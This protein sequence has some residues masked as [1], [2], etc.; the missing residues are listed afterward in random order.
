[1]NR[2]K[3]KETIHAKSLVNDNKKLVKFTDFNDLPDTYDERFKRKW[4]KDD[5]KFWYLF[6]NLEL[7]Y[8]EGSINRYGIDL[9]RFNSNSQLIDT[10]FQ[11]NTKP[12]GYNLRY[13]IEAIDDIF[14][15][16]ANCCSRGKNI[17]FSG[18]NLSKNYI[19]NLKRLNIK[20][21]FVMSEC[22]IYIEK[23]RRNKWI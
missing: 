10:I 1:M 23:Q 21:E 19:E 9:E 4:G 17:K 20:S 6:D 3:N 8:V 14:Y 7:C 13:F 16:Q 22:G 12:N 2:R 15:P 11:L 18:T 5:K